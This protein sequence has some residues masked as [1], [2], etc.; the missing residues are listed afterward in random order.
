[1]ITFLASKKIRLIKIA[2]MIIEKKTLRWKNDW[3]LF[4]SILLT[5]NWLQKMTPWENRNKFKRTGQTDTL[6]EKIK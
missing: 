3:L 6:V 1:M 4:L 2:R 5:K